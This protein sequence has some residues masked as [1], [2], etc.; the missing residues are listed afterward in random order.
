MQ[1]KRGGRIATLRRNEEETLQ[2]SG[3][4]RGWRAHRSRCQG[5]AAAT[6]FRHWLLVD[7]RRLH[8]EGAR[9]LEG[10][11]ARSPLLRR[12]AAHA[13]PLCMPSSHTATP[14]VHPRSMCGVHSPTRPPR[15]SLGTRSPGGGGRRQ[16]RK[17]A[18]G[19]EEE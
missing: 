8:L 17:E 4:K 13:A 14:L 9:L 19:E 2:H 7:R 16:A 12:A 3:E 10:G 11:A 1:K 6:R 15:R 18:G 5:T